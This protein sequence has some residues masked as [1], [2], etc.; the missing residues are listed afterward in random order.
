MECRINIEWWV[1]CASFYVGEVQPVSEFPAHFLGH[2]PHVHQIHLVGHQKHRVRLSAKRTGLIK[3]LATV[4]TKI[5]WD[6]LPSERWLEKPILGNWGAFQAYS[7]DGLFDLHKAPWALK[8]LVGVVGCDAQTLPRV[9]YCY[10][11][12]LR[13]LGKLRLPLTLRKSSDDKEKERS[14]QWW[15]GIYSVGMWTKLSKN[16]RHLHSSMSNV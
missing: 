12:L 14:L 9:C 13:Y 2:L 11:E 1:L 7:L 5:E 3:H 10:K 4:A 15:N 6:A 8:G 16:V